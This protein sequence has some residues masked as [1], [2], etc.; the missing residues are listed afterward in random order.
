LWAAEEEAAL[1]VLEV[2]GA[3]AEVSKTA[4]PAASLLGSPPLAVE[5]VERVPFLDQEV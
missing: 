3:T 2:M 1:G 4:R 5:V